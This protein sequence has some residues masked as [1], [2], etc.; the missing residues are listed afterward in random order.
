MYKGFYK[1][2]NSQL[3]YAPHFVETIGMVLVADN[4]DNYAY[5]VNGWIWAE[6]EN[7]AKE[8]FQQIAT[9]YEINNFPSDYIPP[10]L[11]QPEG[12]YLKTTKY[13][14]NEFSKLVSLTKLMI[15]MG[16]ASLTT[17]I[18]ISDSQSIKRQIT[19][20]RFYQ[21]MIQYG[22]YCYQSRIST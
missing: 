17:P 15:E 21:I 22:M 10:F 3:I 12:F 14:E 8:Y 4:K 16:Q 19:I 20:G 9:D 11:V 6:S 13:D 2:N 1:Y 5:P 7:Q 18:Y